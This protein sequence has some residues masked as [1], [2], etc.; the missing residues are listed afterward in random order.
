MKKKRSPGFIV[1]VVLVL[2]FIGA[3]IFGVTQ[4]IKNP[5]QY[6]IGKNNIVSDNKEIQAI[7]DATG[8]TLENATEAYDAFRTVSSKISVISS[9]TYDELLDDIEIDGSKGYRIKTEFSK[10]VILTV[11]D[12]KIY[13]IRYLGYD[14][15]IDGKVNGYFYDL[16]GNLIA[17][18]AYY[19]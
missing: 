10:N 4:I 5:E 6:N 1:G 9:V 13:S 11:L 12:G 15:Y 19:E 14:Y 2:I 18:S 7:I 8:M 16:N 3:L 17:T